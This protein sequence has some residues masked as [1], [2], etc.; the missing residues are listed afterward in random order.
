MDGARWIVLAGDRCWS[1][2]KHGPMLR[3]VARLSRNPSLEV[4]RRAANGHW[5][6]VPPFTVGEW[7]A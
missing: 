1:Y 2:A 5:E 7:L 4:F 3:M 6:R